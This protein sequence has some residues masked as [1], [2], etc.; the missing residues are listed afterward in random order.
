MQRVNHNLTA[1]QIARLKKESRKSGLS[2]SEIMRRAIDEY[3]RK[4]K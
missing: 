2:M 4:K 1:K 3:F